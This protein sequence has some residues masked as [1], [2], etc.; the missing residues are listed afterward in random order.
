MT[1]KSELDKIQNDGYLLKSELKALEKLYKQ[2]DI[3]KWLSQEEIKT[4]IQ[5][6][7]WEKILYKEIITNAYKYKP[8]TERDRNIS[9][10]VNLVDNIIWK[11]QKWLN[12]NQMTDE[13]IEDVLEDE[14]T[15]E[16]IKLDLNYIDF[17]EDTWD[18][19][20]VSRHKKQ[21]RKEHLKWK[22][23]EFLPK[24]RN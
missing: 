18:G 11:L 1:V 7:E 14:F 21:W 12:N 24:D 3:V 4:Y 10:V 15:N 8:K 17:N 9:Y 13:W 20:Y 23:G 19:D 16:P 6:L 2:K 5:K 22:L